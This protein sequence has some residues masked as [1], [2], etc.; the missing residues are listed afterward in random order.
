MRRNISAYAM[1]VLLAF[2]AAIGLAGQVALEPASGVT[3]FEPGLGSELGV[4]YW[5]DGTVAHGFAGCY[6]DSQKGWRMTCC[7]AGDACLDNGVCLGKHGDADDFG[8][9]A[10]QDYYRGGCMV[11]D[12]NSAHCAQFC[13]DTDF[14]SPA[15]M[16]QC[17]DD[18]TKWYC[19]PRP[20]RQKCSEIRTFE[21]SGM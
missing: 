6:D 11:H 2:L 16:G 8:I 3:V 5:V 19:K 20:G 18:S 4:C 7:E 13:V 10:D 15:D 14:R 12:W 21:L 1:L 9:S 17:D